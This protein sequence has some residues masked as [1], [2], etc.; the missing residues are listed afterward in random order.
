VDVDLRLLVDRSGRIS[1]PRI[2]TVMV[3]GARYGELAD[4]ISGRVAM[5]FKNFQLSVTLGQLRGVRVFVTGFV[6]RPGMVT[7]TSLSSLS[8]ALLRA[9]GPA[10]AGSF[11]N[12]ELRRGRDAVARFDL[13][14]LL[15]N[16]DRT[17]D[18]LLQPD[19]VIHVGPVGPQVALIGSVNR[20]A[21][22]E[23]KPGET[24]NDALRMSGGFSAVADTGKLSLERLDDRATVRVNQITLP[25]QG[26]L[27]L[28]RGDVLRAFNS[29][30]LASPVQ[31]QNKRVRVE[32][33]VTRPGEY[34]MP[35]ESTIADALSRAGGLT[36]GAFLFG[37]DFT[38]ESVR[39]SQQEN[40][41]RALRDLET[42]MARSASSARV[43]NLDEAAS[44]TAR[45]QASNRLIERLRSIRPTGRV[46]LQ[47]PPDGGQL[48]NLALEDGDRILVPPRPSAVGVFGSIFNAGNYLFSQGRLV[49]DYLRLAGG[50]T[51]GAD[52]G[53][54]Y[55]VRANGS[56]VSGLQ[57]SSWI[58]SSS[59]LSTLR[60]EPGDTIFVPEVLE[61]TTFIQN[62]KDWTQILYQFGLGIAGIKAAVQ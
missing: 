43:S 35:P 42:D 55:V 14:A 19:D 60:V 54:T 18:V 9:G 17:A 48:P 45:T 41:E 1:I 34:L 50:P 28:S 59:S 7:V 46:V 25:G 51:R 12:I 5:V 39:T 32:G 58:G 62:A 15:L 11:R 36:Q 33:E 8:H 2:G 47:L 61:K 23:L 10:A 27:A 22:L 4:L 56:V 20:P 16:G 52:S 53:S 37:T 3:A 40:Y 6:N 26:D 49:E 44:Q 57:G 38:R 13:Y 21:V 30:N 29:V 24:V 31:R